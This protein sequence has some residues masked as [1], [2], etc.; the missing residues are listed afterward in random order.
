MWSKGD[1]VVFHPDDINGSVKYIEIED[2]DGS[3]GFLEKAEVSNAFNTQ[4]RIRALK[5]EV[6]KLVE[7]ENVQ[8]RIDETKSVLSQR[9]KDAIKNAG[10]KA[11]NEVVEAAMS[12][13]GMLYELQTAKNEKVKGSKEWIEINKMIIDVTRMKQDDVQTE[14]NTIHH[15][16]PVHYPTGCQDCLYSRCNSCKYKKA[17]EKGEL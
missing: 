9:Q 11:A 13:E 2:A 14:N 8:N 17:Y 16:L 12:K 4:L 6:D 3:A 5:A 1:G 15:Y 7:N 10:N